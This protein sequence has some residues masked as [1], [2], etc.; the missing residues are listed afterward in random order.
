MFCFSFLTDTFHWFSWQ[1]EVI[2]AAL[3]DEL[4]DRR[5]QD[6]SHSQTAETWCFVWLMTNMAGHD[7]HMLRTSSARVKTEDSGMA[8][9]PA[10]RW[11]QTAQCLYGHPTEGALTAITSL[12]FLFTSWLNLLF[13]TAHLLFVT[14]RRFLSGSCSNKKKSTSKGSKSWA[15][16]QKKRIEITDFFLTKTKSVKIH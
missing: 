7:D 10:A 2:A 11:S 3:L 4:A 16:K 9:C 8:Q 12:A 15:K 1:R 6:E 13:L 5:R 14:I